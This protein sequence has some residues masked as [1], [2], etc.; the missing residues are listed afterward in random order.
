MFRQ[1][2]WETN[3]SDNSS[4]GVD[5]LGLFQC[6]FLWF[7]K[8]SSALTFKLRTDPH[9]LQFSFSSF[10]GCFD[11]CVLMTIMSLFHGH[12]KWIPK[13]MMAMFCRSVNVSNDAILHSGKFP[14]TWTIL[15]VFKF[16]GISTW[17]MRHWWAALSLWTNPTWKLKDGNND[18][19][20]ML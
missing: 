6:I 7:S 1:N 2:Q 5:C 20:I 4:V 16:S 9:I 13:W 18:R 19:M 3:L 8:F 12:G 14:M 17:H 10:L 11:N 15:R